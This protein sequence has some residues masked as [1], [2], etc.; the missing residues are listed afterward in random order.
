[1]QV[2]VSVEEKMPALQWICQIEELS[3]IAWVLD[4]MLVEEYWN[5]VHLVALVSIV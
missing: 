1:L 2:M 3:Q 4:L 5:Q